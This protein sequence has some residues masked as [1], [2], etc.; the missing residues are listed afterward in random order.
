VEH[1]GFFCA[2]DYNLDM[3]MTTSQPEEGLRV[4]SQ[5]HRLG[6]W[7]IQ[8]EHCLE[9]GSYYWWRCIKR[10]KSLHGYH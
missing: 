1:L 9:A 5:K 10:N 3:Q 2:E 8:M 6:E 4:L 7:V